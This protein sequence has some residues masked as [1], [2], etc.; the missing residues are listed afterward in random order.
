MSYIHNVE[1]EKMLRLPQLL[2][3]ILKEFKN[4]GKTSIAQMLHRVLLLVALSSLDLI[5]A[6]LD[7]LYNLIDLLERVH[8]LRPVLECVIQ[9][10]LLKIATSVSE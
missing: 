8:S 1:I 4:Y 9:S 7:N 6:V 2:F 3:E 5:L 10:L